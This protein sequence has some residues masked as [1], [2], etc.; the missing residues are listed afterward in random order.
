VKL[1]AVYVGGMNPGFCPR[2]RENQ[3]PVTNVHGAQPEDIAEEE[4]IGAATCG[5]VHT[6]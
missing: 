4:A 1:L 5:S 2:Q 3:P 6:R